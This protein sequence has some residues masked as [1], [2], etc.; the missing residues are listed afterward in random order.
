MYLGSIDRDKILECVTFSTNAN[1]ILTHSVISVNK[2]LHLP[3]FS[4]RTIISRFSLL[5]PQAELVK[6]ALRHLSFLFMCP[7]YFLLLI[8]AINVPN[9]SISVNDS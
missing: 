4:D 8:K 9:A 5:T 6:P 1:H 2:E 3:H 7:D